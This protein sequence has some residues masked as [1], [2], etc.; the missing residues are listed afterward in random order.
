VWDAPDDALV[1]GLGAGDSDAAVALVRRFQRRIYGLALTI[2][3]DPVTAEDVAQE[4]FLR[5]W[6]HAA[7]Y[8]PRRAS[9]ATWLLTITRNLSIDAVRL[10]RPEPL[11]PEALAALSL[12]DRAQDPADQAVRESERSRVQGALARLPAEQR[13]ALVLASIGGRTAKEI[14]ETEGVPLGT[15]K[16]R[17]RAAMIKLRV[18]LES[19]RE[20]ETDR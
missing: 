5:A 15:A 6:R 16:T 12:P 7:A 4:T 20:E 19:E 3:G 9:V 14:C 2:V 10:R 11:N 8:D 13:R 18:D 1:A 17:I